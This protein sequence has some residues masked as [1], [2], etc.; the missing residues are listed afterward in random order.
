[1]ANGV[2]GTQ[3]LSAGIA[4]NIYV[5]NYSDVAMVTVNFSNRNY[6]STKVSIAISTLGH[7]GLLASEWIEYETEILGKA[8]FVKTGIAVTPG[9]YI[10][11]KSSES[12]VSAQC[13]GIETGSVIG[14]TAITA[15]TSGDGPTFTGPSSYTV[16]AGS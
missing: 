2:L 10:V 11:V 8:V 5:N 14:S 12:N 1:M 4:Q 3:S 6:V 7:A 15:N 9:Q 16:I 13:W